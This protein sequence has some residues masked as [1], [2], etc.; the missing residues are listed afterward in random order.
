MPGA[1]TIRDSQPTKVCWADLED[2]DEEEQRSAKKLCAWDIRSSK[3]DLDIDPLAEL[4][5]TDSY[6]N[7][8]SR[9]FDESL[10][11][12][13]GNSTVVSDECAKQ[14][15]AD[16]QGSAALADH[17]PSVARKAVDLQRSSTL[18]WEAAMEPEMVFTPMCKQATT[19]WNQSNETRSPVAL[20]S[21]ARSQQG[22]CKDVER[23]QS[24]AS[25]ED[26]DE[27]QRRFEKRKRIVDSIKT[28]REY[29]YMSDL[30]SRGE[31]GSQ[32]PST[33][34]AFDR[35]ISKRKWEEGIKL[36]KDDLRQL[37]PF[38]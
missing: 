9:S 19:S 20:N 16:L 3:E 10:S 25:I 31:L 21:A 15:G 17:Q 30:R 32:A 11:C 37:T 24:I 26:D 34:R 5:R 23:Y 13:F 27:W 12:L 33:P 36:W 2:S 29:G 4:L 7:A 38:A 28:T 22:S 14:G 8:A 18:A 35:S 6:T 1:R